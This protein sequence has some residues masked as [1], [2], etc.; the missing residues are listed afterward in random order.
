MGTQTNELWTSRDNSRN[1]EDFGREYWDDPVGFVHNCILW[2]NDEN[3]GPTAY[4]E[5]VLESLV[6]KRR[7]SLRCGHGGGKTSLSSWAILWFALTRD[8]LGAD[9][10]I[11]TT[12][13]AWRQLQKFLWPEV[14]KW[15]RRLNWQRIGRDEFVPRDELQALSL[16]LRH[17]SAFAL[18]SNRS[19]LIEGAH[20]DHLLYVFD[21]SKVI[22]D[23]TWDSAEGAMT[24]KDAM[25][26]AVS[27]PGEPQ[28]RF[29]H[30]HV[31][32]PG[33]EDWHVRHVTLQECIAAGRVSLKWAN[34]R[35]LQWGEKSAEYQKRVLGEFAVDEV[36][37]LIPLGWV[38]AAVR[39]WIEWER[40]GGPGKLEGAP[41]QIGVDV[42]RSGNDDSVL[43]LR[44][45]NVIS[46]L[47]IYSKIDTM[48]ITGKIAGHLK[49]GGHTDVQIDIIGIGSGVYDR[50][51]ELH[52]DMA[53]KHFFAFHAQEKTDFTD[54]T[55]LFEFQDSYS[56]AWWNMREM[57]DP[58]NDRGVMLP[59]DDNLVSDLTAPKWRTLS[60]GKIQVER[61]EDVKRRLGRSPDA[62]DAVVM[63]FWLSDAAGMEFA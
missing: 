56:A 30:I 37:G 54:K 17:G 25:W 49:T 23:A 6:R 27:T 12:A 20:A 45:G 57:L 61:K 52:P 29:Y 60:S 19:D 18:A 46:M 32:R 5:E 24:T 48:E 15:T 26:L 55:G 31:R 3:A 35:R 4:Q 44:Y 39:R 22:P 8:A 38:E 1:Y 11:P 10:K 34:D 51:C 2:G 62:G 40:S 50:L 33:T 43:A 63:A 59:P 41:D 21:E 28:G 58:A 9:W 42:A 13:S 53:E 47:D 14:H 7:V 16:S 36:E